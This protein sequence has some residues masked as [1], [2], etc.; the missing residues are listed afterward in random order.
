M[1]SRA[2]SLS[3]LLPVMLGYAAVAVAF[4]ALATALHVGIGMALGLSVLL[5]SGA[6][7]STILGMLILNPP[8]GLMMAIAFG[9]NLRHMLY[10]PHLETHRQDW[11]P[12]DRIVMAGLLTDE[13]Y[14]LGLDTTLTPRAWTVTGI[15]LYASWIASTAAGAL[16]A[17][18]LPPVWLAAFGLALPSLFIGLL[19]PRLV[20]RADWAAACAAAAITVAGR[21]LHLPEVFDVVPIVLGAT[22][23]FSMRPKGT[24]VKS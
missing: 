24:E 1:S 8:F 11:R 20:S 17:H 16:A 12:I 21:V 7:Q 23:A 14:A 9:V 13:L 5:Y 18:L 10:G 2:P 22:L 15:G 19:V 6:L 3:I 4:G